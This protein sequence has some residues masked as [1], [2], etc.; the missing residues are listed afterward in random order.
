M[1]KL[2]KT[3]KLHYGKYLY[4]AAFLNTLSFAFS[5]YK[6]KGKGKLSFTQT[7]IN[8][9]DLQFANNESLKVDIWR[10]QKLVTKSEYLEAKRIFSLLRDHKDWRIRVEY[11]RHMTIY[12]SDKEL[13]DELSVDCGAKEIYEPEE[14][15]ENFLL[16]NID[17]AIVNTVPEYEFRVYLKGNKNDSSFANWLKANTDKSRVGD[18]TLFNIEN[19]YS[20]S[21]NYFYIRDDRVLT[22]IRMLVGHNIRRVEKLIFKGDIDKYKY[23]NDQ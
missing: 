17:T 9:L 14:G 4:K 2:R 11:G 6:N 3:T 13:L 20:A 7:T 15:M 19:G 21:G 10:S 23:D 1:S 16:L 8:N 18:Q 5:S 22:M 12:T